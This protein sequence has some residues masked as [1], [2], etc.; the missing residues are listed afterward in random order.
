MRRWTGW[1]TLM[2]TP[3]E[4]ART[5]IDERLRAAGWVVQARDELDLSAGRG[6]AV[7][8][9]ALRTGFAD[10]LLFVERKAIGAVE[11]KA[12]GTPL[13]GI[14]TQSAK[15]GVG[16]PAVPAAWRK[17][18]PFPYESTAAAPYLTNG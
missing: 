11:A 8:E 10:Y 18:L 12:E 1:N 14:E 15:Y 16:L 9:F 4:R 6:V 17:P 13:S 3:E 7:S 5:N 2:S